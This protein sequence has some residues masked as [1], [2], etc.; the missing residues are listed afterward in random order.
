MLENEK[1]FK[2]AMLA[3]L[4][5]SEVATGD[6]RAYGRIIGV[7]SPT[8]KKNDEL[9]EEIVAILLGELAPV[10]ISKLGAPVKNDFVKP[11]MLNAIN[12]I[13]NDY[14]IFDKYKQ[15]ESKNDKVFGGIFPELPEEKNLVFNSEGTLSHS[16][17]V[18]YSG[19]L[20]LLNGVYYLLPLDC[21]DG[22]KIL[23]A[24]KWI[25]ECDLREGDV[26][27]CWAMQGKTT[28]VATEIL[29]INGLLVKS[30]ERM[31]F[32][33][34]LPC[35]PERAFVCTGKSEKNTAL[36]YFDWVSPLRKGQRACIISPPKAGKTQLLYDMAVAIKQNNPN[37][38]VFALLVDQSPE[39][40]GKFR[41]LFKNDAIVYTSYDDDAEFQ[42]F[43][44]EFLLK[45]VKRHVE[46]GL[47][48]ILFI[49]SLS[50]LAKAYNETDASSGGKTLVSGL[51][52][53]TLQ[54]IKRFF[55]SA[56]Q[57]ENGGS[58]TIVGTVATN[59]GN[60]ADELISSELSSVANFEL[61][62]SDALAVK[63]IFP[64]IEPLKTKIGE[65]LET[66]PT[67]AI[68][69]SKYLPKFGTESFLA[70]IASCDTQDAFVEAL[71]KAFKV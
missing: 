23:I 35:Y 1:Q 33:E 42:V 15:K 8:T 41:R 56:R 59:T 40:V 34:G 3:Y 32:E 24:E 70:L 64:A 29:T 22:K 51:E 26:V 20:E 50:A 5:S 62:L 2:T 18:V 17:N 55:A 19:Q 36:K 31:R 48:V 4:S 67:D 66:T 9:R 60:P 52:S 47:D 30:F 71:E 68:L 25:T 11:T 27:S 39:S 28:L 53:K 43:A 7:K 13:C 57:L 69:R 54:F 6:L 37:T 10:Q 44:A 16:H 14:R 49:D 61:H 58:L 38:R 21:R 46:H 63:R 65:G 12:Q 45:R